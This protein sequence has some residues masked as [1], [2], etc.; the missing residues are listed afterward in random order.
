[1]QVTLKVTTTSTPWHCITMTDAQFPKMNYTSNMQ[2]LVWGKPELAYA[3]IWKNY[4]NYVTVHSL[5]R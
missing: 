4:N 2:G 1:M 3:L 5:C